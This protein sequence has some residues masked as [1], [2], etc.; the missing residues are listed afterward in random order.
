MPNAELEVPTDD[1]VRV[2]IGTELRMVLSAGSYGSLESWR[3]R[4]Q[5]AGGSSIA[6]SRMGSSEVEC[7][8]GDR[9]EDGDESGWNEV[10]GV[11]G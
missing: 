4:S 5:R 9:L 1:G 7:W 3:Q 10:P 11:M 6:S 8:R 2:S